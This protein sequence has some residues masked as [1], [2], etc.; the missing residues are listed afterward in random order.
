MVIKKR[1]S[2]FLR[3]HLDGLLIVDALRDGRLYE[4]A[5]PLGRRS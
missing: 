4:L 3:T 5:S 1:Y 2:A